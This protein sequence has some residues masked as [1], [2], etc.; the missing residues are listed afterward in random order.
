MQEEKRIEVNQICCELVQAAGG[1][2]G[3]PITLIFEQGGEGFLCRHVPEEFND[4]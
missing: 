4:F 3:C 1:L 2:L